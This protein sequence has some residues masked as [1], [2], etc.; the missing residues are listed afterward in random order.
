MQ[1]KKHIASAV[2]VFILVFTSLS[3]S[4]CKPKYKEYSYQFLGT[5]DTVINVVGHMTSQKRFDELSVYTEKRFNELNKLYDIYHVYP[6]IKNIKDIND[7]AGVSAVTVRDEIMNLLVLSKSWYK[8]TNGKVNI[9]FGS[10]L[11]IWHDYRAK[12]DPEDKNPEI[13]SIGDLEKANEHVSI[14][15]II[16]N[17]QDKTVFINDPKVQIDIGAAAKGYATEIVVNELKALGFDSFAI[18]AGGNVKVTGKP[19]AKNRDAWIIGIQNPEPDKNL[20]PSN[21][22]IDKISATDTSIVTSG[23]YQRYFISGGKIYHH[24]IDPQT[25]F[26]ANYYKAVTIVYPDSGICDILSTA[27]MLMPYETAVEYIKGI[28]GAEAYF[29][30]FDGSIKT[31]AGMAAMLVKK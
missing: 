21:E 31:T 26:P 25:L 17:L 8:K 19:I 30:L 27:V 13:P 14:D 9:A 10:V 6:G 15:S 28:K 20:I 12:A 18:S 11:K 29:V 4:S 1:R 16:L 22:I 5:F 7:K 23:W 24:I 3:A 2:L